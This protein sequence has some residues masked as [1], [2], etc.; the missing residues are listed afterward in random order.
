MHGKER[1]F[2][3]WHFCFGLDRCLARK[4]SR[5]CGYPV[6]G[7]WVSYCL[8]KV[9]SRG[10]FKDKF[11][12]QLEDAVNSAKKAAAAQMQ[13]SE[14]G[15]A[16]ILHINKEFISKT[17][18]TSKAFERALR[19]LYE[20]PTQDEQKKAARVFE[21][22]L[23]KEIAKRKDLS[24]VVTVNRL[25][26]IS[27]TLDSYGAMLRKHDDDIFSLYEKLT[28]FDFDGRFNIFDE[29]LDGIGVGVGVILDTLQAE[30]IGKTT[31]AR[32]LFHR[33][34]GEFK[35]IAWVEYQNN[36]KESLLNSFEIYN[37]ISEADERYRRITNFLKDATKDTIIF[38]CTSIKWFAKELF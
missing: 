34:K 24:A 35:H 16:L 25:S 38:D 18:D 10:S 32:E 13:S 5:G 17:A 2:K 37:D 26:D 28:V 20:H 9:A 31:V 6:I 36:V 30:G 4:C 1:Y 14:R 21:K 19:Y 15:Q 12:K 29:K 27:C 3:V 33:I 11:T 7:N 8:H 22:C 23:A